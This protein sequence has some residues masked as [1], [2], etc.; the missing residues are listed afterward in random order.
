[1]NALVVLEKSF[2][3]LL[4]TSWQAAV[5]AALILLAQFLLR[6]RL[7]A[8]WRHGLWFL[9]LIRLLMPAT[10]GSS[11]SI[12]NLARSSRL[13]AEPATA[14]AKTA[15]SPAVSLAIGRGEVARADAAPALVPIAD[16]P[17][18]DLVQEARQ[19]RTAELS[20]ATPA[21]ALQP[22]KPMSGWALAGALWLTGVALLAARFAWANYRFERRL[23]TCGAVRDEPFRQ[24]LRECAADLGV[25]REIAAIETAE[26]ESPAVYGW[27]RKRLLL[28][29][30]LR[31]AMTVDELRHVLRHEMGHIKRRDPELNALTAVLQILHWF[32]PVL[33]FA[34]RRMRADRELATD[35]LALRNTGAGERGA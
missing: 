15:T 28:P 4:R 9:L 33:W 1:M 19:K 30:G 8:A 31:E 24:V 22:P 21:P 29:P 34:F 7:S 11:L 13:R 5:L 16:V 14:P 10:P 20:P 17:S 23:A 2:G 25:G 26:V 35:E 3:W 32:N 27:I 18:I 6:K 12:F